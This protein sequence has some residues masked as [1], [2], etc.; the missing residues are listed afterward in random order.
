[1]KKA[2]VLV[3]DKITVAQGAGNKKGDIKVAFLRLSSVSEKRV[4]FRHF[5]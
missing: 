5:Q 3:V 2:I 4:N 1:M